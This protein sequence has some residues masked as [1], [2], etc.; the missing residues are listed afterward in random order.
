MYISFA[1]FETRLKEI[2]RARMIFKFA[3]DKL[4]EGQK[5][6]LYNA[7]TQFEKQYGG[8]DGIEHVVMSKRR[9]KYEEELAETPHNYDVWFD[10]IRLEESTDRHEKIREVY[11][12]AI[13]QVPPAAEKRYWRRYIYLW[14]FYAVWEET[15]AND[16][17]RARQV[18]INCI[19]LIPHK[20]FTFSKV[21]VMY[22]HFLIRLLDLTQARKVLG[23]AIGMCPKERLFKS[24]IELELSLRDFDRVRILY[25]KYL[26]WNPVNCYGWIKFAELESMLGDEDRAR[27]IFEAAIAQ[28]ALDMPEILWKS[29]IDF[30]IKETE[31]KNARE[32]Y[33][34]LLQLTDHVK[35][36]ISFANFEMS[37]LDN[38]D[39]Q[40]AIAQSRSRFALS[41]THLRKTSTKEERVLLLE[42]WRDFER[43][44]GTPETLKSV[45][46]KLP[47]PVK[48]RRRVEDEHGAPAGWDEYYDYIFPDDEDEKPNFKLL[49]LAHQWKMKMAAMGDDNDDTE[50]DDEDDVQD[51]NGDVSEPDTS[52]HENNSNHK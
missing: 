40:A 34:R 37:A 9:I 29:Y 1:K 51:K 6:N 15:V 46:A 18:Y 38:G 21:W 35:V 16:V 39:T 31:W 23:Q 50:S 20:Q 32:L 30:E 17:E 43:L 8:K 48:K 12:R 4:P 13:A 14:L 42:A 11:E 52:D 24:Y 33:H 41:N 47:R 22:S 7:Y 28:P 45:V 10:Y 36:H 26:E 3:L 5:E 44:H 2:E 25:Q 49:A 19:K 27:A